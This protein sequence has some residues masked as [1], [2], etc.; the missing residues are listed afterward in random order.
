MRE[1][2]PV[3]ELE[4]LANEQ[5]GEALRRTRMFYGQ[6]IEDVEKA[7]RIR[8]SQIIA[9][10]EGDMSKLPG[11]VY[12]IGF[13]RSYA[14]YL[15]LDGGKVVNLY[16]NQY[17]DASSSQNLAFHVP[18]SETK[19]P[20]IWLATLFL[21]FLASGVLLW[22]EYARPDRSLVKQ[23]DIVSQNIKEHIN[24]DINFS[25]LNPEAGYQ[26]TQV[27]FMTEPEIEN[28]DEN[29][30][31]KSG[32]ILNI[33]NSSWVEI[34]NSQQEVIVSNILETGEQYFVPDNPGLSMSLGNAA[35]VEIIVEGRALQPLGKN[36]D[37]RRDIP[38]NVDYLKTLA[39]QEIA[40]ASGDVLLGPVEESEMPELP[41]VDLDE[42]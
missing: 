13:V 22:N 26:D 10:E 37:V 31:Q 30:E 33:L 38:L 6:S 19:T 7:L 42:R 39:F 16:K 2:L 29:A 25:S 32:I 5:M 34:K 20:A 11:R 35:N 27:T 1:E 17:M 9:I 4:E 28:M 14:E 8:A 41:A 15:G 24:Q 40:P 36:G 12:A 3:K 23:I 18:A 21:V